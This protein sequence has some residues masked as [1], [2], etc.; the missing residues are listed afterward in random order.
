MAMAFQAS[1]LALDPL[2]AWSHGDTGWPATVAKIDC[3]VR[4]RF[5]VRLAAASLLH[6]ALLRP[7]GQRALTSTARRKLLPLNPLYHILH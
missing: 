3:L 4:A 2:I 5:R 7:L 1:A 6:P